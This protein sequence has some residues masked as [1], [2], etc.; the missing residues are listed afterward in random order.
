MV[1]ESFFQKVPIRA[2]NAEK[3]IKKHLERIYICM[4]ICIYQNG[5]KHTNPLNPKTMTTTNIK[6]EQKVK[7]DFIAYF[8]REPKT[9]KMENQ[10]AYA[11]GFYCTIL[12]NKTIKKIH[13][14][15]WRREIY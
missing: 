7:A 4:Y 15:S 10:Y 2:G 14:T 9:F 1:S 12:N 5:K 11:D 3:K 13:G 8:G 6:L